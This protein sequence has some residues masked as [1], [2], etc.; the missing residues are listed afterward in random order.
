MSDDVAQVS[1]YIT[2]ATLAPIQVGQYSRAQVLEEIGDRGKYL[3]EP[4]EDGAAMVG[5][6]LI[7]VL[8]D[9]TGLNRRDV[10]NSLEFSSRVAI[11]EVGDDNQHTSEYWIAFTRS[12]L[13]IGWFRQADQWSSDFIDGRTTGAENFSDYVIENVRN[14]P[15]YSHAE[16]ELV[17]RAL[18]SLR[19]QAEKRAFFRR[20]TAGGSKGSYGVNAA[21]V[22]N[23][24]LA[25]RFSA[26]A[27]NCSAVVE[28]YLIFSI[29]N[30]T[31]DVQKNNV[32]IA[33]NQRTIDSVR[34]QLEARLDE[35]AGDFID[36]VD[37]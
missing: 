12:I 37:I 25:M 6:T 28:D 23:G 33:A 7:S 5:G 9:L 30:I 10:A 19:S 27:F 32:E 17:I 11:R 26:F 36:S 34:S 35:A 20:F 31:A 4:G 18:E 22:T 16:K 13:Q 3:G 24:A 21:A 14:D 2:S 1:A 8:A 29:R 15:L